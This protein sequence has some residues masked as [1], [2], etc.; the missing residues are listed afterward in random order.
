VKTPALQPLAFAINLREN[1]SSEKACEVLAFLTRRSPFQSRLQALVPGEAGRVE[2]VL[3]TA[4]AFLAVSSLVAIWIDPTEP[5]RYASLAYG[6]ILA[7][8]VYSL[9]VLAWVRMRRDFGMPFQITLQGIDVLWPAVISVFTT[10]ASSPFFTLDAFVL[11]EAAYRWGFLE[12]LATGAAEILLYFS[13][14]SLAVF[15][16]ETFRGVVGQDLDVNRMIMR[17]LYLAIMAY[18][19]GYLGEQEKLQHA[20]ASGIA[21]LIGKVQAENGLRGA[22][23]VLFEDAVKIFGSPRALLVVRERRSGR[24]VVWDGAA[25]GSGVTLTL[26]EPEDS[27]SA[28]EIEAAGRVWLVRGLK[29]GERAREEAVPSLDDEGFELRRVPWSLPEGV[30]KSFPPFRTALVAA[31]KPAGDWSGWLWILDPDLGPAPQTAAIFLRTLTS[32]LGPIIHG[33]FVARRLRSQAGAMERARV[34]REL[35]DGVIQSLIGMEMQVDVLRRKS[36]ASP[37]HLQSELSG[38]QSNLHQEVLNLRELMQQMKPLEFDSKQF[39]EFL[40]QTVDK[41]RRDTGIAANFISSVDEASLAPRVGN[42]VARIVQEA[43]VNV[44]R[45]SG[46]RNVVVRFDSRGGFWKLAIDDDGCGFDFSGRLTQAELDSARKG[47]VVIK[48]RVRSIGG[49]LTIESLPGRGS[50]L[51]ISFPQKNHG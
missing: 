15:G 4:R 30:P 5:S 45:H 20:E 19:L 22:L 35:H 43:L 14:A 21:R 48:E 16:A 37:E 34:A 40:A 41:F 32:Q 11:L 36:P 39:L 12:T 31:A 51:E 6:L 10:P 38:L 28:Y 13:A 23:R 9:S 42:E 29:D 26:S 46:A 44:R 18:L 24:V 17:P 1:T 47:P 33:I 50:R 3:A 8:A 25:Q 7:Y 49:D 27:P 2:R